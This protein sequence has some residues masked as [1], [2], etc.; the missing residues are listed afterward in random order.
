L[1]KSLNKCLTSLV[2]DEG[3]TRLVNVANLFAKNFLL[4]AFSDHKTGMKRLKTG[5]LR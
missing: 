4:A 5:L 2:F 1:L 3:R